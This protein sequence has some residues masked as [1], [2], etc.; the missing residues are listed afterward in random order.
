MIIMT[1]NFR[2]CMALVSRVMEKMVPVIFITATLPPRLLS[3][4]REVTGL[5]KNVP[6]IWDMTNWPEIIYIVKPLQKQNLDEQTKIVA[7]FA[8]KLTEGLEG[9]D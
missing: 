1:H 7:M 4:F 2:K 9:K 8:A 5:P 3:H 6:V